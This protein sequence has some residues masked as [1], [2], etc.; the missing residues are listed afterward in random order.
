MNTSRWPATCSLST[1]GPS[2]TISDSGV[3]GIQASGSCRSGRRRRACGGEDRQVVQDSGARC[4]R[5]GQTNH[6][7]TRIRRPTSSRWPAAVMLSPRRLPGA[8]TRPQT[9]RD[10]GGGERRTVGEG[11]ALA[12]VQRR[13]AAV[14]GRTPSARRA[15][16]RRASVARLTRTSRACVRS[17][18]RS[19]AALAS[20]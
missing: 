6:D 2:P 15:P 20:K 12:E 8:S 5:H 4:E 14:G 7:G 10:V 16:V 9:R 19:A 11:D 17:A 1:N 18:I 13:R 3:D